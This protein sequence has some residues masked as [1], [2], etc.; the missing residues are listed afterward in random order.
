MDIAPL[1][2][3][4][5][6]LSYSKFKYDNLN[7]EVKDKITVSVEIENETDVSGK[8]IV[9]LYITSPSGIISR[10]VKELKGFKKITL[11]GHEKKIVSF[12]L[13]KKELMYHYEEKIVPFV[14]EYKVYVG[15]NSNV[16]RF[17]EFRL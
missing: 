11:K 1:Y 8:E 4:G 14:G 12:V 16:E 10:P 5:Y 3:F 7:V 6:G 13:D 2:P 17:K 15:A 9:E